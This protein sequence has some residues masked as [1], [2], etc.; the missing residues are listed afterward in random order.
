M[1]PRYT[2]TSSSPVHFADFP[3]PALSHIKRAEGPAATG[4]SPGPSGH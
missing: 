1:R 2:N 3:S 4:L